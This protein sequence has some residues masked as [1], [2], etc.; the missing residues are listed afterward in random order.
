MNTFTKNT[1]QF[2][3]AQP[4]NTHIQNSGINHQY[5][6]YKSPS[7]RL[8]PLSAI[9]FSKDDLL[10]TVKHIQEN[11]YAHIQRPNP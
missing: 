8:I 6:S 10:H 5:C 9:K 2:P 11:A 1:N 7:D 3:F 4:N